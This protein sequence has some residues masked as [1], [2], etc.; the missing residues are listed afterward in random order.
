[1]NILA[2]DTSSR[3]GSVALLRDDQVFAAVSS[4][5][6]GPHSQRLFRDVDLV[7]R[8]SGVPPPQ[9][10]VYA[11]AT[12]PGSFTGVRVGVTAVKAWAEVYSKP[13]AAVSALEAMAAQAPPGE[14]LVA[15][16]ADAHRGQFF[17][18]LYERDGDA[19]RRRGDDVVLSPAECLDYLL[20]QA[21]GARFAICTTAPDQ[22]RAA[23]EAAAHHNAAL[24]GVRVEQA[25]P[26]LA[27][28][29]GRLGLLRARQGRLTDALSLDAHYVRR[30][31]AELLWKDTR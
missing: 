17:A 5:D 20:Q 15:G 9:V 1:M 30:S 18:G 14:T 24:A 11:V 7:L 19:L 23:L 31:D 29:I 13:V 28:L 8:E 26:A 25:D 3:T 12:G 16:V 2:I 21:A 4:A 10:D 22:V 6:E 27:P